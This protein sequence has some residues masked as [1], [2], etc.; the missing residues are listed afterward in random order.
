MRRFRGSLVRCAIASTALIGFHDTASTEPYMPPEASR[1]LLRGIDF[2]KAKPVSESYRMEFAKCDE[3]G[4]DQNKFEGH[5][6]KFPGNDE[7]LCSN[8]PSRLQ[9]LLKLP[10]GGVYWHSK[11]ALDV[12]G[13]WAA[14][15]VPGRTDQP[16]TSV[17]WPNVE[18]KGSLE[19][20][21]DPDKFPYVAVPAAT[22]H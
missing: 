19:A 12:D 3:D 20:Q 16:T 11:M 15:N 2:S 7:Y 8:D 6:V 9:A 1:P 21:I 18:D 17:Q 14:W 22:P 4:P 13:S 10:N 5:T